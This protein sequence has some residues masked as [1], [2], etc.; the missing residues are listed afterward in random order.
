MYSIGSFGMMI[1]DS[2][3]TGAYAAALRA[4]I[5]PGATV[6]DI[7]AG[8]GVLTLLACRYGA[9]RVYAIEPNPAVSVAAE[10]ARLNGF[11]DR[12]VVIADL[13]TNFTPDRRVDV[14]VSDLHGVLP[15]W[16]HHIETVA[17]ARDRLLKPGGAL[18]PQSDSLYATV[19][20]A[21]EKYA[22]FTAPWEN[23][24]YGV[25]LSAGREVSLNNWAKYRFDAD[26]MLVEPVLLSTLDYRKVTPADARFSAAV[27]LAVVRPGTA[28]GFG[29]WFDCGL[30][31]GIGFSNAPGSPDVLY[32]RAFFPWLR[33]VNV[34]K[35]W[36]VDA[37][38]EAWP[39]EA[40]YLWRWAGTVRDS[41]GAIVDQFDQSTFRGSPLD[42][43][44]LARGAATFTPQRGREV[45]L[46]AFVLSR[47]SGQ[48]NLRQI[49]EQLHRE[50]S[51]EFPDEQA[52]FD[53]VARCC[54]RYP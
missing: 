10:S 44:H 41:G 13:S 17:D 4:A 50:F 12:V 38:L 23:A 34:E 53:Y 36:R 43:S 5:K 18:I 33:P 22:D 51:S 32:G 28:H 49:G 24:D 16:E 14:V 35:G 42:V 7:G 1:A 26:Q 45:E 47:I 52:A 37:R 31:D 19:I 20:S 8:T 6:V 40:N 15:F 9:A 11:E 21:P 54:R 27:E 46:D 29:V 48:H 39:L 2:I 30:S 3:R 25:D